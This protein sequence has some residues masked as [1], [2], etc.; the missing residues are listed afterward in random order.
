[1]MVNTQS[2]AIFFVQNWSH[3]CG[4]NAPFQKPSKNFHNIISQIWKT[5]F[6]HKS[7]HFWNQQENAT[8]QFIF[9]V[10]LCV[11]KSHQKATKVHKK[12]PNC[13]PSIL[14]YYMSNFLSLEISNFW[15][16]SFLLTAL[17]ND[18]KRN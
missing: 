15:P 3:R 14:F 8:S 4:Q 10:H 11:H 9:S 12:P 6:A 13:A 18:Y 2:L 7:Q 1:M 16:F 5:R 17:H